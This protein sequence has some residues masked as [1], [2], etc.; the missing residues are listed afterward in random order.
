MGQHSA[1]AG[2]RWLNDV[3]LNHAFFSEVGA[4]SCPSRFKIH[5]LIT[6]CLPIPIVLDNFFHKSVCSHMSMLIYLN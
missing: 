4:Q 2:T 6:V 1:M 3:Q 5:Q